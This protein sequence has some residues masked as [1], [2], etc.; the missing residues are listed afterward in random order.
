MLISSPQIHCYNIRSKILLLSKSTLYLAK[1]NIIKF[2]KASN[3]ILLLIGLGLIHV[4]FSAITQR[5][6][7][8]HLQ[9][10]FNS[11]FIRFFPSVSIFQLVKLLHLLNF[12][13]LFLSDIFDNILNVIFDLVYF[14]FLGKIFFNMKGTLFS[15]SLFLIQLIL[16]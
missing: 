11:N 8:N 13:L 3:A 14:L 9:S 7:L 2:F 4:A 6:G 12:G 5:I 15:D 1:F 10:F 16:H